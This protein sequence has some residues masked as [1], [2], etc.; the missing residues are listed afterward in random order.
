MAKRMKRSAGKISATRQSSPKR[1][2]AGR[3]KASTLK[4]TGHIEVISRGCL[5]LGSRVLVT[6]NL[7]HGY[8]YLPGG[9]VEFGESAAT[10]VRREFLEEC[11]V[12]IR[13]GSAALATEAAFDTKKHRHHEITLVFHVEPVALKPGKQGMPPIVKSKEDGIGF[14]WIDLAAVSDTDLR[15]PAVKAWLITLAD[16][17]QGVE[18]VS[19][20]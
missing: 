5:I 18:W 8:V 20:M 10:A 3:A 7:K 6:R 9:H 17:Q 2:T 11:G 16:Q 14:E 19:D 1:P 12:D 13:V 4:T 15:P